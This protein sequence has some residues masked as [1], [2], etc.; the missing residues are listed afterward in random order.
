MFISHL[1]TFASA[2][3]NHPTDVARYVMRSALSCPLSIFKENHELCCNNLGINNQS[4]ADGLKNTI[5]VICD[6][7]HKITFKSVVICE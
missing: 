4:T 2:V 1:M 6:E 5:K 7:Q 3:M